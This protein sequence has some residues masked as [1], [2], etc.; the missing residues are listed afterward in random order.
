MKFDVIISNPPYI[1][2]AVIKTLSNE[3]KNE[4]IIALDGGNDGLNFYRV[5]AQNAEKYLSKG[6]ILAVEI[7]YNQGKIVSNL[8]KNCGLTDVYI[9]KD[10]AG[11][12]RIVVGKVV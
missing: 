7:G 6:G 11:N 4:P 8:F 1:E 9:K 3:V 2:T 5:L 12:D 10:F